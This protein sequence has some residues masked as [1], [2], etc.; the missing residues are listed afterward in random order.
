MFGKVLVA[1]LPEVS[2]AIEVVPISVL[3]LPEESVARWISAVKVVVAFPTPWFLMGIAYDCATPLVA[4]WGRRLPVGMRSGNLIT[5]TVAD[6]LPEPPGPVQVTVYMVVDA[7][8]TVFVPEVPLKVGICAL[9]QLVAFVEVQVILELAPE[10]IFVG[11]AVTV[12]TGAG[13]PAVTV[14]TAEALPGVS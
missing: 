14:T 3:L 1:E 6:L 12:T 8:V 11:F 10:R 4:V 9:E 5:V 7:G 13:V 2:V